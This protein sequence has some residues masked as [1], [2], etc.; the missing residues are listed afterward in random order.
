MSR[1]NVSNVI[2]FAPSIADVM[3]MGV[4]CNSQD[5]AVPLVIVKPNNVRAI[6][7]HGNAIQTRVKIAIALPKMRQTIR[8]FRNAKTCAFNVVCRRNYRLVRPKLLVGAALVKR[9]S[10]RM[11]LCQNIAVKS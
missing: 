7:L 11:N 4:N 10:K 1:A 3:T 9:G 2:R 8:Q 5:V 6:M